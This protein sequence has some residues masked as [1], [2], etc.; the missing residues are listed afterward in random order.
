MKRSF[1]RTSVL[2]QAKPLLMMLALS[3]TGC[4]ATLPP[5]MP[6]IPDAP[7]LTQPQPQ[8]PYSQSAQKDIQIWRERL[9]GTH[10]TP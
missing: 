8:E 6:V 1:V 5:A 4:A 3:L 2:L 10:K 7:E 9:M